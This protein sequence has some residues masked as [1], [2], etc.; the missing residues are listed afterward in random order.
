MNSTNRR[1]KAAVFLAVLQALLLLSAMVLLPAS[2]IARDGDQ[3]GRA[4]A[5]RDPHL[6]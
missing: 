1:G 3:Q 5:A 6:R 2:A 4:E